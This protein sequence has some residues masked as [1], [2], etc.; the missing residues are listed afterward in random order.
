MVDEEQKP[1]APPAV[2]PGPLPGKASESSTLRDSEADRHDRETNETTETK[3]TT[4][5]KNTANPK[6]AEGSSKPSDGTVV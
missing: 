4:E 6:G 2:A 1:S 3:D 5:Q